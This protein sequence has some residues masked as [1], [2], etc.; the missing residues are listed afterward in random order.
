MVERPFG[1]CISINLV[2]LLMERSNMQCEECDAPHVD[3]PYNGLQV[4]HKDENRKNNI[5]NNLI[6]LCRSCHTKKHARDFKGVNNPMYG[7]KQKPKTKKLIGKLAAERLKNGQP[8]SMQGKR[9]TEVTRDKIS[10]TRIKRIKEGLIHAG[11]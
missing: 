10:K 2:R 5:S 11:N 9:H 7:R 8:N 6:V 3:K 1:F 4:H